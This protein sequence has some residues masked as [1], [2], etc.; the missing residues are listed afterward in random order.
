MKTKAILCRRISTG[1]TR[2][3]STHEEVGAALDVSRQAVGRAM[4]YG[5]TCRG[6]EIRYAPRFFVVKDQED[7]FYLC[8]Y[9]AEGKKFL[10][11]NK[12]GFV[13]EKLVKSYR[14]VTKSLLEEGPAPMG[15]RLAQDL[16]ADGLL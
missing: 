2:V 14:D 11:V 13:L 6:C 12:D 1:E 8:T 4:T 7:K 15:W 5:T 9:N 3:F 16:Q 10:K